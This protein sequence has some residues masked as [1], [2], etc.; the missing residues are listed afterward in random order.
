MMTNAHTKMM[1]QNKVV[2]A[3]TKLMTLFREIEAIGTDLGDMVP[4]HKAHDTELDRRLRAAADCCDQGLIDDAI[5][6]LGHAVK[7]VKN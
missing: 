3:H 4:E 6:H 2:N 1:A 5:I 7:L